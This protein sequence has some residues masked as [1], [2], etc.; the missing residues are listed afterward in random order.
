MTTSVCV[1]TECL[2]FSVYTHFVHALYL[3]LSP[4]PLNPLF[5]TKLLRMLYIFTQ[6]F[7]EKTQRIHNNT[8]NKHCVNNIKKKQ[9]HKQHII[10]NA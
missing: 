6:Q 1:Y 7:K 9:T 4:A 8:P 3:I 5:D 2:L 10:A